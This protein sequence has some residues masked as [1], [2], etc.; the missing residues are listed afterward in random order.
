[1]DVGYKSIAYLDAD[2]QFLGRVNRSCKK[3]GSVVYFFDMDEAKI[4]YKKDHRMQFNLREEKYRQILLEKDF[5]QFYVEV[6]QEVQREKEQY[7]DANFMHVKNKV[8]MLDYQGIHEHMTLIEE[9]DTITLF[10]NTN[11]DITIDGVSTT[12]RG[13]EV[14]HNYKDL[15]EDQKNAICQKANQVIVCT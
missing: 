15:L 14:W 5:Y 2:E 10:I 1:M 8:Q 6:L 13:D 4:I 11:E 7:N 3:E 9:K 12:I